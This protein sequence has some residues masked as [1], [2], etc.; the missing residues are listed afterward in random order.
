MRCVDLTEAAVEKLISFPRR[1]ALHMRSVAA[2]PDDPSKHRGLDPALMRH[3]YDIH[4]INRLA[5]GTFQNLDMVSNLM[6]GAMEKDADAFVNQH[7]EFAIDPVDEL[8][9]AMGMAK[10]SPEISAAYQR[11]LDVMVYGEQ[12]PDFKTAMLIFEQRLLEACEPHSLLSFEHFTFKNQKEATK[13]PVLG[14]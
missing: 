1:L 5:P 6:K 13:G 9:W 3:I 14:M 8:K 10:A 12:K 4:E 2:N 7:P 11:F